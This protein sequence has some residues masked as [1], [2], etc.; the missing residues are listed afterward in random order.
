MS[1]AALRYV[2]HL[3]DA[4][5]ACQCATN[6][7]GKA[8]LQPTEKNVLWLLADGHNEEQ[9]AYWLSVPK[10]AAL[11]LI[12]RR[13]AQEILAGLECKGV[14]QAMVRTRGNG[15]QT[16]NYYSFPAIDGPAAA[17]DRENQG[18]PIDRRPPVDRR[19]QNKLFGMRPTSSPGCDVPHGE[20]A[21][22]RIPGDATDRM[23]GMRPASCPEPPIEPP[24]E[25]PLGTSD[26]EPCPPTPRARKSALRE[27]GKQG[28]EIKIE[29]PVL[30]P[31]SLWE[32]PPTAWAEINTDLKLQF[33]NVPEIGPNFGL[34]EWT[35][36][37][38]DTW[39]IDQAPGKLVLGAVD[40]G[41]ANDG[42][43]KY[44][45]RIERTIKRLYAG[46]TLVIEARPA[47]PKAR[48]KSA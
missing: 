14:I 41:S 26:R 16:S 20:D 33:A 40:A 8:R 6:R 12:S 44:Q 4:P 30:A 32:P 35:R 13:R 10:I 2:K 27:G 34:E 37:F 9:R 28:P 42:L 23:E 18:G 3:T 43:R 45:G 11:S 38:R 22:D 46:R 5:R 15:S 19:V 25:P 48:F 39:Q 31:G 47:D 7:H 24:V 29:P 1:S 36:H 21:T 17:A